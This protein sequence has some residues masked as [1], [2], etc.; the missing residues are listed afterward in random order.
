MI[1]LSL[2]RLKNYSVRFA[3]FILLGLMVVILLPSRDVN[4]QGTNVFFPVGP[5]YSDVVPHQIVRTNDDRVYMIGGTAQY[6]TLLAVYWTQVAGL[7]AANAFTGKVQIQLSVEP[8][9]VEAAYD[10]VDIIHILVNT[11]TSA[12]YDYPFNIRTNTVKPRIQISANSATVSGDYVGTSGLS[13]MFDK[14]GLLNIVYWQTGNHVIYQPFT[15]NATSNTLQP[16][17][18]VVTVD[19]SGKANHPSLAISPLDGSLTIAWVSEFTSPAK[20]LARTRTTAGVWGNEEVVSSASVWTS[21]NF[22]LNV[23]QGPSFVIDAAGTKHIAYIQNYDTTN[24]YGR[25]HYVRRSTTD[26]AWVDTTLNTYSHDP[27]MAINSAG[28]VYIIGHGAESAGLNA[29]MYVSKRNADGTWGAAQLFAKHTG[30]D[31][32]DASPSVKW[33]AVGWNRPDSVEFVFFS[34]VGGNYGNTYMYYGRLPS[35][36]VVAPT[37]TPIPPTK[38]PVPPTNTPVPPTKTPAPPTN[39]PL[40]PTKT[41]TP[42]NTSV[43]PSKTPL[44]TTTPSPTNTLVPA[45]GT[46]LP[47]N[48][49]VPPTKTVV[50]TNTLV[51]PTLTSTAQPQPTV[52]T[53]RV[54]VSPNKV[55]VGNVISAT[56]NLFNVTTLYGVQ[57]DCTVDPALLAGTTHANGAI[58]TDSNGFFVDPGPGQNG[59]WLVAATRLQPAPAFDGNGSAFILQYKTLAAGTTPINCSILAVDNKGVALPLQVTNGSVTIDPA[60]VTQPT[61]V[62]PTA[63]SMVAPTFTLTPE[64][65]TA[66]PSPTTT[67]V[68]VEPP[69][70]TSA[71]PLAGSIQGVIAYQKAPDNV[72]INIQLNKDGALVTQMVTLADGKYA[73]S[74]LAAGDYTVFISAPLHLTE[75]YQITL[76]DTAPTADLG[77]QVLRAGDT[78]GNQTIDLVDAT[79]VSANFTQNAPPAPTNAD[80]NRDGKVD[81][82]DLVLIGGNFGMKGPIISKP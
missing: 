9:S 55:G 73:F 34:A 10:G 66:T 43:P 62:V 30:T 33:S 74:D 50:P 8:L 1:T 81:I 64:P 27:M 4:A 14:T 46:P 13:G 72:G 31:S 6:Q 37:N 54:D 2:A 35:G 39:T 16:T 65:P 24:Q 25:V 51:P 59:H 20:I 68:V 53:G 70:P 78:D 82:V 45:S 22:G 44:P 61:A 28:E 56:I 5:G 21:I 76:S 19:K 69:T 80:L 67:A 60:V 29:D 48:T 36:G 15:Y 18:A 79:T 12:L 38:T 26:A 49:L 3:A 11:R 40:P 77:S 57:V 23:D 42:T 7:P 63:T 71:A 17:S 75:V 58:F 32:F 47:T 41:S 52:P